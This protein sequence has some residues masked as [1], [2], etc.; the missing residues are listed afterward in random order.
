MK[1]L[2][3]LGFVLLVGSCESMCE[4]TSEFRTAR[5][6]EK[7]AESGKERCPEPL[8]CVCECKTK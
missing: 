8:P 7:L 5:A 3:Y 4:E 6:L 2:L 1:I